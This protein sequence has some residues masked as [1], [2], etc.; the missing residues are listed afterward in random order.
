[1]ENW[2]WKIENMVSFPQQKIK[3]QQASSAHGDETL[4]RPRLVNFQI[5]CLCL[6]SE[7]GKACGRRRSAP[8][9]Q[10]SEPSSF[11]SGRRKLSLEGRAWWMHFPACNVLVSCS[12]ADVQ[13]QQLEKQNPRPRKQLSL[14][15][16][17]LFFL[18]EKFGNNGK[19]SFHRD[20]GA[21]IAQ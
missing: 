14:K 8:N 17:Y 21:Y 2:T 9:Q 19:S 13:G 20:F 1:M 11:Q 15:G 10:S 4:S 6:N 12:R 18:N 16:F 7:M 3:Q 5:C